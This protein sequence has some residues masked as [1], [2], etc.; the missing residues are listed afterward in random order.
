MTSLILVALIL[1]TYQEKMYEYFQ[2][3]KNYLY[4]RKK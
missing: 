2:I 1:Y 3:I 4:K